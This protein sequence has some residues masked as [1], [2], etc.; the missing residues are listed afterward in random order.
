MNFVAGEIY[1]DGYMD[2]VFY[3]I[4]TNVK[5]KAKLIFIM[6]K[7]REKFQNIVK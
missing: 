1:I 6:I 5:E 2:T 4:V 3:I 7:Q